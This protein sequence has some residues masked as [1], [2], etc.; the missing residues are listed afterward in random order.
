[1]LELGFRSVVVLLGH[2]HNALYVQKY[3]KQG[4]YLLV[5]HGNVWTLLC[6]VGWS[7]L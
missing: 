2:I 7:R 1:M 6:S 4:L 3:G 5:E